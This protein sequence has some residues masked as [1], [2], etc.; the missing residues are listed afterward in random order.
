MTER[1]HARTHTHCREHE[2]YFI[3]VLICI[4]SMVNDIDY[5][6]VCMLAIYISSLEKYIFRYF[7]YF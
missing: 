4:A 5:L 6:F 7:V 1:V 3:V 2:W